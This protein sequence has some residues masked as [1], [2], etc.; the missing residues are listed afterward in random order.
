MA[1]IDGVYVNA[2]SDSELLISWPNLSGMGV[3]RYQVYIDD[4]AIPK[5]VTENWFIWRG[6]RS[7]SEY[8]FRVSYVLQSGRESVLSEYSLSRTWGRD[9]SQDNLPDDWQLEH[10][11]RDRS[12][13]PGPQFDSDNDGA[14][15]I[16]EFLAGTNPSDPHS[17]LE[18]SI[19][20][21]EIGQR[22]TWKAEPGSVYQLQQSAAIGST[23][24]WINMGRPLVASENIVGLS[25][26]T[27]ADI[28]FY[29]VVRIR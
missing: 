3:K 7:G 10:F 25:M 27:V 9:L 28:A 1:P 21:M 26:G 5:S 16:E 2:L 20:N 11:G 14:T 6:L 22:L 24:N 15:N 12:V 17:K 29:R 8:A 23:K 4:I 19:I 13:W 18:I